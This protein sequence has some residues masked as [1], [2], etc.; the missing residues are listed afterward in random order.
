MR[1]RG[2]RFVTPPRKQGLGHGIE[3]LVHEDLARIVVWI[4]G[5]YLTL[6]LLVAVP[7]VLR[8][9]QRVDPVA[10]EGTWGFRVLIVPG[11]ALLWPLLARRWAVGSVRPP[12]EQNAHRR[13]ASA[14][15]PQP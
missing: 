13:Q 5:L 7:F 12:T 9:V 10:R 11:V 15:A 6:G 1:E 4:A 3:A 2:R 8:G 14:G